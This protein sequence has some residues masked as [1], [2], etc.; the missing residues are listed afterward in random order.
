MLAPSSCS[1][2]LA[3]ATACAGSDRLA[4]HLLCLRWP[5]RGHA[6][7]TPTGLERCTGLRK[8][9]WTHVRSAVNGTP[10]RA[11]RARAPGS[12]TR[13]PFL[14]AGRR[15]SANSVELPSELRRQEQRQERMFH[16]RRTRAR[17]A[18]SALQ[19]GREWAGRVPWEARAGQ[20]NP[21]VPC[22]VDAEIGDSLSAD[23]PQLLKRTS[24][25]QRFRSKPHL[26][27]ALEGR[28]Q[29][30]GR[31]ARPGGWWQICSWLPPPRPLSSSTSLAAATLP[32]RPPGCMASSSAIA[33]LS[34]E[35]TCGGV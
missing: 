11:E 14:G 28:D 27:A 26:L 3:S 9:L 16:H 19:K 33:L 25:D 21:R 29:G 6:A 1:A 10:A 23:L 15:L 7:R 4:G 2:A 17:R 32:A 12:R 18:G 31:A 22:V 8:T 24:T 20:V 5:R 13:R 34:H 30:V 35:D